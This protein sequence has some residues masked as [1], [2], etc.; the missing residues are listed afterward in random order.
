MP[1]SWYSTGSSMVMILRADVVDLRQGRVERGGLAA[2][3][4]AGDQDDAVRP[5]QNHLA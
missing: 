2:A 1:C 5:F 3:G 4:R